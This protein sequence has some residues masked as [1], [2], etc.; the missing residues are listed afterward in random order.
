MEFK[1]EIKPTKSQLLLIEPKTTDSIKK[2]QKALTLNLLNFSG[3][4]KGCILDLIVS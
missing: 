1:K 3:R 2:Y 4:S